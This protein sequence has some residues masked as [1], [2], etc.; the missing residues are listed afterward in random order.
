MEHLLKENLDIKIFNHLFSED[1]SN[2]FFR[3]LLNEVA[4]KQET[5]TMWGKKRILRRRVA[6]YGDSGKNYSYSGNL[7]SPIT[8]NENLKRIKKKIEIVSSITFNSVLLNDYE[9]GNVGMGWHSDDEKELGKDPIIG[10]VSFGVDRDFYLKPK[11]KSNNDRVKIMSSNGSLILMNGSTQHHWL[12]SLPI[13]KNINE[14]RINLTFRT[15][16]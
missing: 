3:S 5:I 6:W 7:L 4:W 1:E 9:D 15:I 8:W 11:I 10:S 2:Y 13:R 16:I 14:R 12:H